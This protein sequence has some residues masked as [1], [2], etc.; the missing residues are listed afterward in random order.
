MPSSPTDGADD[1]GVAGHGGFRV[2]VQQTHVFDEG[3]RY[4]SV[5]LL[6]V[7]DGGAHILRLGHDRICL[8]EKSCGD[9]G[10]TRTTL[11]QTRNGKRRRCLSER[12]SGSGAQSL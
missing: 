4:G 3:V 7:D 10:G 6:G 2:D 8:L 1:A 9:T 12:D 5:K 11:A